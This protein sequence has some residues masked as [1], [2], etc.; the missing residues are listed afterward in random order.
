MKRELWRDKN[1][2][3]DEA[4]IVQFIRPNGVKRQAFATVG[5]ELAAKSRK[6]RI[7]AEV[8]GTGQIAIYVR[9]KNEPEDAER[10]ELAENGPGPNSPTEVLKRMILAEKV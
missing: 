6:L 10:L 8:L 9:R 3:P 4:E 2:L 1:P 7:S 5:F